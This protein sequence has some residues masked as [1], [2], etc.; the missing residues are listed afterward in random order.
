MRIILQRVTKASV[1]VDGETIAAIGCGM[2]IL[3]GIGPQDT[4]ADADSLAE[5]C[6]N[7][8]IFEDD[9]GKTNLSILDIRGEAL[10]VSQFTL[11]ADAR[12]GRRP[13]FTGAA[14]PEK[15]EPL[16]RYFAECLNGMGVP[17]STG[18]FG[19]NMQVEMINDGPFTIVLEAP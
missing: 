12:K 1:T 16:V 17:T 3:L 4:A 5:K 6:A 18:S 9:A 7:L 14:V 8:R 15:A 13:S 11:Y 2:L 10:V 19:A